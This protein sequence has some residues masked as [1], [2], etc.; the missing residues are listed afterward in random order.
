MPG[1]NSDQRY[2][3]EVYVQAFNAL[4]HVNAQTFSGVLSSPFYG[5]VTETS[6]PRRIEV[7]AR[8][9]F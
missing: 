7:G 9:T 5:R 4:N 1:G 8:V 3:L 6:P 2:G